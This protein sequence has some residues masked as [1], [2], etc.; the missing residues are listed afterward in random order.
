[1][2]RTVVLWLALGGVL[3]AG[4]VAPSPYDESMAAQAIRDQDTFDKTTILQ[5]AEAVFGKGASGLGG[6]IER[7]FADNGEP[8]GFIAGEEGAGAFVAGVRYGHGTLKLR[9]GEERRV[10]WQ[11]PSIG[12]DF[13]GNGSK[14]FVLV[15]NLDDVEGVFKRYPGVDGSL[16][17]VGGLGM[18]YNRRGGVT[19]APVR[20]GLARRP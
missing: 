13:G 1:M 9:N 4:C 16:Y 7:A 12:F 14:A 18:N 11:G 8:T 19:L 10:F 3:S 2:S 15:Y 17:F 20:L 5:E 6:I